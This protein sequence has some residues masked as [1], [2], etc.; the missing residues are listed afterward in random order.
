VRIL[1]RICRYATR[2][3]VVAVIDAPTNDAAVLRAIFRPSA[4]FVAQPSHVEVT[5]EMETKESFKP[6]EPYINSDLYSP[7][8][9][10]HEKD[11]KGEREEHQNWHPIPALR[12]VDPNADHPEA[13]QHAVF[14][15][16]DNVED[17]LLDGTLKR[18]WSFG[19]IV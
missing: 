15:E 5:D 19:P 8:V 7:I 9:D 2:S 6:K 13:D 18:Q 14:E 16:H 3:V 17:D 1:G 11:A 10:Q 4:S 12:F